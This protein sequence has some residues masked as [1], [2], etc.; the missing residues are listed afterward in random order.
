MI[1]TARHFMPLKTM[2]KMIDLM[3]QNKMNVLHWHMTD[4]A[5]FPFEST[6]FPNISRYGSFQPFS[7][8]YTPSDVR[9]V[10]EYSRLR[11]IRVIPEFDTPGRFPSKLSTRSLIHSYLNLDHTQSWGPFGVPKLLTECYDNNGVLMVPDEFGPI[12]PTREETYTFLQEFF[13]EIFNT[14][15]DP[16]VHLGGDE[17][18]YYCWY[19]NNSSIIFSR[20]KKL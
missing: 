11:G 18:S 16:Y 7:H 5:S 2:K 12:M 3:A 9:A 10:I 1:D 14:F 6:L 20:E 15:P 19:M 17:I 8:I 4:D 13:G